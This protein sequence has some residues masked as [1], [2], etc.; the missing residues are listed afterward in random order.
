MDGV[1]LDTWIVRESGSG[2]FVMFCVWKL[3]IE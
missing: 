2:V 1:R 3:K